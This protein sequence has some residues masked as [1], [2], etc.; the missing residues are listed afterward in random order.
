MNAGERVVKY[1]SVLKSLKLGTVKKNLVFF[2][3]SG[4][5]K[6]WGERP[7]LIMKV[8][9]FFLFQTPIVFKIDRAHINL[10]SHI[11]REEMI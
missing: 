7:H 8:F 5:W 2:C 4:F 10:L 3:F 1:E 11:E 9:F 6:S